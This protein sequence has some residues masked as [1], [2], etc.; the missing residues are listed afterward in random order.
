MTYEEIKIGDEASY[1]K[2]ITREMVKSFA[3][4]SGDT[5]PVHLDEEY[6]KGT[7]FKEN[8]AHGILVTG[9]I[10]KVLGCDL[11]GYGSIYI[12]QQVSFLRPVKIGD[13]ITAKVEAISKED[14]RGYITFKTTCTNQL[15]KL[16]IRGEAVG[17]APKS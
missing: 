5:N 14:K 13:V 6:A 15:G 3:E 10:S 16:V 7:V 11:P 9:L 2:E 1:T 8:I 12:S 4:I 17:M